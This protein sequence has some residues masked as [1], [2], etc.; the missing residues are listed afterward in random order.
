MVVPRPALSSGSP[1]CGERLFGYTSDKR[2]RAVD[3]T[4][5]LQPGGTEASAI[6]VKALHVALRQHTILLCARHERKRRDPSHYARILCPLRQGCSSRLCR[7]PQPSSRVQKDSRCSLTRRSHDNGSNSHQRC[8]VNQTCARIAL[9]YRAVA[10]GAGL[11]ALLQGAEA[12]VAHHHGAC[13]EQHEWQPL[14]A[15][16]H[17]QQ[18]VLGSTSVLVANMSWSSAKQLQ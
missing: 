11:A 8:S 9:T 17:P 18:F 5:R 6:A 10:H 7:P 3:G 16:F 1:S 13:Q 15:L 2:S 14:A 4:A 12:L